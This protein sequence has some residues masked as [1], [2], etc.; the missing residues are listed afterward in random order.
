[1]SLDM[2]SLWWFVAT[3]DII[4]FKYACPELF[5]KIFLL[6]SLLADNSLILF[7]RSS[8]HFVSAVFF[9]PSRNIRWKKT[10]NLMWL[11]QM[12]VSAMSNGSICNVMKSRSMSMLISTMSRRLIEDD[13]A[14][15]PTCFLKILQETKH[16]QCYSATKLDYI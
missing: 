14:K 15:R 4:A 16:K 12:S 9:G 5:F 11:G 7:I 2:L 1:M 3:V 8:R 6:T 10:T 13:L